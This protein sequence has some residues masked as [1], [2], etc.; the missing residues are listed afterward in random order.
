MLGESISN[1]SSDLMTIAE[2]HGKLPSNL[3]AKEDLL[4]SDVFSNFRYLPVN[5]GLIPFLRKAINARTGQPISNM[6]TDCLTADYIFW[7]KITQYKR[8]PDQISDVR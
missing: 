6:F 7:P 4:T 3:E 5:L 8:E 2:L 1:E